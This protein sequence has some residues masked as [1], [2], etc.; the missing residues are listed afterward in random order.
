MALNGINE[1]VNGSANSTLAEIS[2]RRVGA[3]ALA[4]VARGMLRNKAIAVLA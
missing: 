3:H 4:A 1:I 2:I